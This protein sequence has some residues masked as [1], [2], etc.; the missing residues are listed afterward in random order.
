MVPKI[1][2]FF[3]QRCISRVAIFA[4]EKKP[5]DIKKK[6]QYTKQAVYAKI[7]KTCHYYTSVVRVAAPIN[8]VE[9]NSY[10]FNFHNTPAPVL[11]RAS[12][13]RRRRSLRY[14]EFN[15]QYNT[16]SSG[17]TIIR[18]YFMKSGI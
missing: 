1:L 8:T 2:P 11:Q 3:H 10:Y 15:Y 7:N 13:V 4:K 12:L 14:L 5:R 6:Y 18:L 9:R 16:I 17:T